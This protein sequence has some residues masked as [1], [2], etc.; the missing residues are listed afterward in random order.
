MIYLLEDDESIR[1]FIVYALNNMNL[2]ARGFER[3]SEFWEAMRQELPRLVLLDIMLPEQDGIEILRLLREKQETAHLPIIML[4]AKGTE[5]DKVLGLDSGADDY[6]AKPFGTMELVSRIKA[7]LR[8]T[9]NNGIRECYQLGGLYLEPARH[10]VRVNGREVTLTLKEF[11]L[12]CMLFRNRG[13]VLTRDKILN[14]VWGYAFDGENRTV[15]VHIRTLRV[16]LGECG[17]LIETV[18]GVGYKI[19]GDA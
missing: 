4:T 2:E 11:D 15:D 3:P 8:R 13:V 7:L 19:G 12:L 10:L 9:E 5:Y 1:N 6:I 14:E 18:R 17:D 16:K